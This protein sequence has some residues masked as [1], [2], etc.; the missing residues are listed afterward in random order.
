MTR[1][2]D[3]SR[4]I[5][6]VVPGLGPGGLER[7]VR[8]LALALPRRGFVPSV[9][10]TSKLG[11]HAEDLV[12]AGI[13]VTLCRDPA[14]RV[15]GLPL[16]L[17]REL[18]R[19]GPELVHA[20]SG[21]WIP[22]GIATLFVRVPGLVLTA[23]GQEAS[24][25]WPVV[26]RWVARRADRVTAVSSSVATVLRQRLR[27]RRDI[28]VIL[29]GIDRSD[30]PLAE[31]RSALRARRGV[32]STDLLAL[33][34]GRLEPV[35][36]HAVLLDAFQQALL[37]A[38]RLRLAIL[39]SGSLE[40]PLRARSRELGIADRVDMPGFRRDAP[41][42][43]RSAD[44]FV[45]PSRDEG[46]PIALLEAMACGLPVVA[47]AVPGIVETLGSPQAIAARRRA[48]SSWRGRIA[49]GGPRPPFGERTRE[50]V[51]RRRCR[52]ACLGLLHR[53][54]G[55]RILRGLPSGRGMIPTE[56][57]RDSPSSA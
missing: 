11:V 30:A 55:R 7:V 6:L 52:A 50:R 8:D 25:R 4:S 42:W 2:R 39:G 44:I 23:H 35:K 16:R 17:I 13:R 34:V 29:N 26:T 31:S 12:R 43:M 49:R 48:R 36:G 54:H 56:R 5:A 10:C 57:C 33:A 22:V 18:R 24:S 37:R 38:P 46:M 1:G 40:G 53:R 32:A 27:L 15:R 47:S 19:L 21:A 45:M 41:E 20:H 9:F 28:H 3:G 51:A 14:P